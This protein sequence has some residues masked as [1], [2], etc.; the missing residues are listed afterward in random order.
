[1]TAFFRYLLYRI[2]KRAGRCDSIK[3]LPFPWLR[4]FRLSFFLFLSV[5]VQAL[6]EEADK[7][8]STIAVRISPIERVTR[9]VSRFNFKSTKNLK[10]FDRFEPLHI[11]PVPRAW[12]KNN[13]HLF[14]VSRS[15]YGVKRA[16]HRKARG[17]IN[18][19][20]SLFTSTWNYHDK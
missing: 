3:A 18:S 15:V 2:R 7:A 6:S 16:V 4:Y 1:M 20:F 5:I 10:I 14:M 13:S 8:I 9:V 12:I 11:S 17:T 19:T